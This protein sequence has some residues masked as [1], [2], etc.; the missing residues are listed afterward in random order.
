MT[1]VSSLTKAAESR[2]PHL[3]RRS[4][5]LALAVT[6]VI[7]FSLHPL[8][9]PLGVDAMDRNIIWSYAPIP[10]LVAGLLRL[11]RKLTWTTWLLET[12]RLTLVK[13]VITFLFA[14][15]MWAFVGPPDPQAAAPAAASATGQT[16]RFDVRE[17]PPA[18]P[19]DPARCG[20]LSGVVVDA[21]G[22]PQV[23]ALVAVTGGLQDR[24][25]APPAGGTVLD[26][27]GD[28]F[29]P[30]R[31]IVL[32]WET[33]VVRGAADVLHT[34][35]A[36][37]ERGR[38]LFNLALVPGGERTLMFDRP[39]GRVTLSC[40]VHGQADHAAQLAVVANPFAAFTDDQ[41]RF[42]FEGVPAGELELTAS[43]SAA[44][45]TKQAVSLEPGAAVSDVRLQLP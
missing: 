40:A 19:L 31:A 15:I 1:T 35:H 6:L 3:S 7:F 34:V 38:Q 12:L 36:L 27:D 43:L 41:G 29:S 11:E 30:G 33:L 4:F 39:L 2:A 32:T 20:S 14:N 45:T 9:R 16:S 28:G 25:F 5:L 44:S 24:V 21:A 37:D 13:F 10:L 26:H 8:W 42:R 17:A 18:T 22:A 23:G